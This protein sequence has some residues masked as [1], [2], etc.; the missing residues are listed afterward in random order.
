MDVGQFIAL[1][2]S[3]ALYFARVH[4]LG[5]PWEAALPSGLKQRASETLGANSP[6]SEY[7]NL[8]AL[9][10]VVSCWHENEY[11]SVAMWRLYTSGSEG[12]ALNTTVDK[13]KRALSN[14]SWSVTIGKVKYIDHEAD[15][16]G[17]APV[18]DT[19]GPLFCKRRSFE[20]EREVRA[21]IANP[22][23]P[24]LSRAAADEIQ[25]G[26]TF[27]VP[28]P[29]ADH[30]LHVPIDI[31]V[32]VTRLVVSPKFPPWAIRAFQRLVDNFGLAVRVESS[33]L[34]K[35]P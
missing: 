28:W 20:H 3:K 10:A 14:Q 1:I 34:L 5:D 27:T 9:Q 7:Y 26:Q 30:G 8:A 32:L 23:E 22:A 18:F 2:D 24:E 13:L 12:V 35:T 11:E 31:S 6:I 29:L 15:D 33:D 25:P 4:E 19:L 16:D 17:T 21:V